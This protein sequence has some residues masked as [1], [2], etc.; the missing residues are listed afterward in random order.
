VIISPHSASTV[1]TENESLVRL[2]LE[3]LKQ[4][5]SGEPMRNLYDPVAGY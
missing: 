5:R 3:N 2:F 1:L 4:W